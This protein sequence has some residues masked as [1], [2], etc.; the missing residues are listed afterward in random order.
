MDSLSANQDISILIR[1]MLHSL[2]RSA[3]SFTRELCLL[4]LYGAEVP[5]A[6]IKL[7]LE[8][9]LRKLNLARVG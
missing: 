7:K 4:E 2:E 8:P 6:S 3:N 9:G 1:K 5:K